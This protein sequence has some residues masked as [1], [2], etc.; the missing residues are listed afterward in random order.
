MVTICNVLNLPNN[1][2]S[3]NTLESIKN[4]SDLDDISLTNRQNLDE[5]AMSSYKS[6]DI[7]KN[8]FPDSATPTISNINVTVVP[9]HPFSHERLPRTHT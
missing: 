5:Q 1:L 9:S 8:S 2:K 7:S 4:L 6:N 3:D